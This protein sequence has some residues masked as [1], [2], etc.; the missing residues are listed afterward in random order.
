VTGVIRLYAPPVAGTAAPGQPAAERIPR[1]EVYLARLRHLQV[2]HHA[3]LD[4]HEVQRQARIRGYADR[5][6]FVLGAVLLRAIVSRRTGVAPGAVAIDRSCG[7]CAAQH[8]RPRLADAG[9][10]ASVSHSGDVVAAALTT[11]GP[12]GVDV[13][14]VA[15]RE[16]SD[17]TAAVCTPAEQEHVREP[18]DF[19]AYWTRKEAVLKATGAG[20]RT[21]MTGLTVTPPGA[22]P[23]LLDLGGPAPPCRMADVPVGDGYAGAVA[24]LTAGPVGFDVVDAGSLL[25]RL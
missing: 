1:C 3:L 24:V 6:R 22:A 10:E 15:A 20:L 4:E 7:Y 17:L 11:A 8:G 9:L 12:V 25:S 16:H 19:Y 14:V 23:A 2:R 5:D 13:E 18:R 21:P